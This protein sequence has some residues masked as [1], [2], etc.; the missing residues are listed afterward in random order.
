[1]AESGRPDEAALRRMI[2][3]WLGN[4]QT[5]ERQAIAATMVSTSGKRSFGDAMF[6]FIK[7]AECVDAATWK[8][9]GGKPNPWDHIKW[10]D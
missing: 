2:C 4:L 10:P 1:M 3:E 5:W 6:A 8:A 7:L 9:A